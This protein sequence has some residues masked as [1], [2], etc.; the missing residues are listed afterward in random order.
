MEEGGLG[1]L[2][3]CKRDVHAIGRRQRSR[4]RRV[5]AVLAFAWCIG[6]DGVAGC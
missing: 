6:D 5:E 4:T 1:M 2:M 3:E